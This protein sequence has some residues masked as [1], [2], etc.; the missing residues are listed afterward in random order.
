MNRRDGPERAWRDLVAAGRLVHD[1]AQAALAGTFQ[2][3]FDRLVAAHRRWRWPWSK[4]ERIPGLY[5]HGRVGR[6]KTLLMDL[7]ATALKASGVPVRRVHF[8][9]FM[10]DAHAALKARGEARDPLERI[11]RDIARETRVL[12]F[13]E[14]HVGDIGDAMILAGLLGALFKRRLCLVAT[15]NTPPGE[16][17]A[18]G[19]QR[20]RFLPAIEQIRRHCQV[21]SLDADQDY[22]LRALRQYPV[23]HCPLGP[24]TDAALAAEFEALAGG[25]LVSQAP[26]CIRGRSLS[27]CRRAGS[28]AWLDFS[29]L[30]EGPRSAADYI[31]LARRLSTL[32]VSNIP[33]MDDDGN[34]PVRRFIHLVDE[35]YDRGVKLVISAAAPPRELYTGKR[36]TGAF[37]RTISRLVEMQ[38]GDYLARAHRP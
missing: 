19:L 38:S 36:L 33:V 3:L 25:E 2:T 37:E 7:F 5:M 9:R 35:C 1:P 8:H 30:C 31:E 28:V 15:S 26:L 4:P 22:R 34:D 14:F 16:L 32:V 13:D 23:Y 17:Y 27:P 20:V 6:G 10:D 29:T 18:G 24:E 12:C 11:A 21:I